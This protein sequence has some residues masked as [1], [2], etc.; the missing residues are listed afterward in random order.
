MTALNA[1]ITEDTIVISMDMLVSKL[2][3]VG[4]L[5]PAY[6]TQK[7]EYMPFAKSVIC[8]TGN[9]NIIQKAIESS[10]SILAKDVDTFTT[11]TSEFLITLN[12]SKYKITDTNTTTVYIFGFDEDGNTRGYAL[13]ST[14]DFS[15][16]LI[17]GSDN[18]SMIFKPDLSS[19][20]GFSEDMGLVL[21]ET[22]DIKKFIQ[23]MRVEKK[24]DD[25][26]T[27]GKVGIGGE[28]ILLIIGDNAN[29][30][31]IQK[32]DVFDDYDEQYEYALENLN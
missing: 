15:P 16:D 2:N 29:T 25:Q 11:F 7:F 24:Y 21:N 23:M 6:F 9:Y 4:E 27:T 3:S 13:R 12:K 10:R 19:V 17:A 26:L 32:I 5:V 14:N 8:G 31:A 22:D 30:A 18:P 28:N 20:P 1:M